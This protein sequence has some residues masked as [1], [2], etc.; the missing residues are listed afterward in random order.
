DHK[1]YSATLDYVN[2]KTTVWWPPNDTVPAGQHSFPYTFTLPTKCPPSLFSVSGGI[3]YY[4]KAV[5]ERAEPAK[6]METTEYFI[7]KHHQIPIKTLPTKVTNTTKFEKAG[8]VSF[9]VNLNRTI[10]LPGDNIHVEAVID[11][12]STATIAKIRTSLV[13]KYQVVGVQGGVTLALNAAVPTT[14]NKTRSKFV[15]FG[16]VEQETCVEP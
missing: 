14:N 12:T 16:G 15:K 13:M 6:N 7:V 9:E 4:C 3:H 11:N 10:F 2:I 1:S 5:V 8:Q